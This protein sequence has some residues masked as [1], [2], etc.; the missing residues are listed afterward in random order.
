MKLKPIFR[1]ALFAALLLTKSPLFAAEKQPL[2]LASLFVDGAILQREMP[3]PVWGWAAPG[4]KV[5]VSFAEQKKTA[6]AD[7]QG[8]WM[9]KLDPLAASATESELVVSAGDETV[10][11]SGILVGE[12]WFASGQSNMDWIAGKSN[13][14]KLAGEL[15]K[16]KTD[17][18]IREY[19]VDTGSSV[20]AASRAASE[21]GW[22]KSKSAGNFS[23]LA[24]A[25]AWELHQELKVPVGIIRSS[26]GATPVET[27]TAYEGF[28]AN[29]Q[30][31]EIAAKIRVGDPRTEESKAAFASYFEA[32]KKWQTDGAALVERGGAAPQRPSLPGI[33]DD[34]KGETRMFN[35]KIAPLIPFAIRGA[36]WNQ[37]EHNSGDGRIYAAKM[38]ALISGWRKTWGQPELPFYFTQMQN[39]GGTEPETVGFA[40]CREAQRLFFMN[41]KNV[42]MVVQYDANTANP[43]GIHYSNKLDP[44]RRMARWALANQYGKKIAYTGPLYRSHSIRGGAVRVQFEQR[45]E[46][47]GLMTGSKGKENT[48]DFV[49][50]AKETPGAALKYFQ[51][52]GK[53]RVWHAADAVIEGEEVVVTSKAV[54]EPV[55]VRYAYSASPVSANLYNRAGLPA[56]P[57][58]YFDGKQFFQEDEPANIAKAKAAKEQKIAGKASLQPAT[59]FR[60]GCVIQRDLPVPVWGHGEPGTEITVTFGGQNRKTKVGEFGFWLVALD[61]IPAAATGRDL[62]IRGDGSERTIKDVLVGDV[63]FLTGGN[64]LAGESFKAKPGET[65]ALPALPLV[66]E[67][68][69]K[70][71]A[72]RHPTPRKVTM[73]IGSGKYSSAWQA[74]DFDSLEDAPSVA[75][76]HFAAQVQ[77]AGV[78]LGVITLGSENP[79]L[80]WMSPLAMQTA[81]GFEKD[82]DQL[83]LAYP[84]T[85]ACKTALVQY[86]VDLQKYNDTIAGL[87]A[88]GKEI[89]TAMADRAPAFPQAPYEEWVSYTETATHTYNFC[90]SPLTPA[91][92]RGV[93]W[94]P[95]KENLGTD[96]DRYVR[97][98]KAYAKSQPQTYTQE[99]VRFVFAHPANTL[100]PGL[101]SPI[102]NAASVEFSEWPKSVEAIAKALGAAAKTLK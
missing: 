11:R 18:P 8:K 27:W 46:G 95:E 10:R 79:P 35:K 99:K 68:R 94:L 34:W 53:D 67:F 54:A 1:T 43:Q 39:Y 30:L 74:A 100:V 41:V 91:A 33:F 86:I 52:A 44:G 37:G 17:M 96:M 19:T 76:Y 56:A 42:G 38:E 90:I 77:E 97:S 78:P 65:I 63:W 6:T 47:G 49:E 82:R 16:S 102:E 87:L 5:S 50:P 55:G 9:A 73:E 72:R 101:S 32:L 36:I 61:P 23:A 75:G 93:V 83:N 48:P 25:F 88:A 58:A 71:K 22:K 81:V 51:L 20:Y 89:P 29:P 59:M 40:D 12:V 24:L 64:I 26:H 28:A 2:E 15:G 14:S 31:Q 4:A 45:G 13:C 69:I 92:V 84:N 3:V 57:F 80:T 62:V 85:E 60:N 66:R 7:A 70:T 21:E 98:L